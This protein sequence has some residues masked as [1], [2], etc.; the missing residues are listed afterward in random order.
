LEFEEAEGEEEINDQNVEKFETELKY[1][2]KDTS[3]INLLKDKYTC[4]S[5]ECRG[6]TNVI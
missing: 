2:F 6:E 1:F 4:C 3:E 5:D